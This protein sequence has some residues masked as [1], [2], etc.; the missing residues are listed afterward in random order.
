MDPIIIAAAV[1]VFA[2]GIKE[3][4]LKWKV[5]IG[6]APMIIITI[7]VCIGEVTDTILAAGKPLIAFA[8]AWLLVKVI[9]GALGG[10]GLVKTA[11]G[12]RNGN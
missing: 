5:K 2:Q 12:A 4:L 1:L 8:T 3:L 10:Y 6:G 7:G 11:S 9:V